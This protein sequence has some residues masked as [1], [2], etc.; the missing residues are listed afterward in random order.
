MRNRLKVAKDVTALPTVS[1]ESLTSRMDGNVTDGYA[2]QGG[3]MAS[4]APS[5]DGKMSRNFTLQIKK[6]V[7]ER[8]PEVA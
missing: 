3:E 2:R 6:D 8:S 7:T 5:K 1:I 4:S